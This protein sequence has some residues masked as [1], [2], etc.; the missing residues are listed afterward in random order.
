MS[1]Q[2]LDDSILPIYGRTHHLISLYVRSILNEQDIP[3]SKEQIIVLSKLYDRDGQ[4]QKEL[5][6]AIYRN[7]TTLARIL[8][9]LEN[10]GLAIRIKD[11][12]DRRTNKIHITQLGQRTIERVIPL[13]QSISQ[14]IESW[15]SKEELENLKKSSIK[16]KSQL[17]PLIK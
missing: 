3:L 7:K 2:N 14:K 6:E 13:L 10:K 4:T 9:K 16:I 11:K 12:I 15:L 1:Q 8:N 5:A 17:Q